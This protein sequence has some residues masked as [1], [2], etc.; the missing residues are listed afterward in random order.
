MAAVYW[1]HTLLLICSG[2]SG[3]LWLTSEG[4]RAE[5][6]WANAMAQCGLGLDDHGSTDVMAPDMLCRR[7][8]SRWCR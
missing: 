7:W 3:R 4:I 2:R 1:P 8:A 6:R 5:H